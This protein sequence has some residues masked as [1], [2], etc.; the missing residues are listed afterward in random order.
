MEMMDPEEVETRWKHLRATNQEATITKV[1]SRVEEQTRDHDPLK[2]LE[3]FNQH[4]CVSRGKVDRQSTDVV[5]DLKPKEQELKNR[6]III[7][8]KKMTSC[9]DP[10]I[11]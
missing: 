5:C 4:V 2:V 3:L 6:K 11:Y 10:T 7:V 9:K 8:S 1:S